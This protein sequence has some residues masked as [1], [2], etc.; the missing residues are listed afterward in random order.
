MVKDFPD[1]ELL[2]QIDCCC[3][4]LGNETEFCSC[5]FFFFQEMTE[6]ARAQAVESKTSEGWLKTA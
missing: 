1:F 6:Q 2:P 4:S 3:I 5:S